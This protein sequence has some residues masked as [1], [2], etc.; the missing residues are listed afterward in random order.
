MKRS[1]GI[2]SFVAII[3]GIQCGGPSDP[4]KSY[5][6]ITIE[7]LS[8]F[9]F[10]DA[11][12]DLPWDAGYPCSKSPLFQWYYSKEDKACLPVW[13]LGCGGNANHFMVVE[14]CINHCIMKS[15]IKI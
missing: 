12:C 5:L 14:D 7:F 13:Y 4:C 6:V 9:N 15:D 3:V 8:F 2:I 10:E 1:A 11:N